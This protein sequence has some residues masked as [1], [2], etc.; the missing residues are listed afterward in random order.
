MP[1]RQ[2]VPLRPLFP[3]EEQELARIGKA[4]SERQDRARRAQALLAVAAGYA[5]TQAAAAAADDF[6]LG[7]SGRTHEC[8]DGRVVVGPRG[9]PTLYPL[10]GIVVKHGGVDSTHCG[11]AGLGGSASQDGARGDRLVGGHGGGLESRT[12]PLYMEGQTARTPPTRPR[13]PRGRIGS[14]YSEGLFNC[15]VTY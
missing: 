11:A 7:Q 15:G 3:L 8:G 1:A 14:R 12:D 4:T 5:F 2:K 10:V 6:D 9:D 13:A